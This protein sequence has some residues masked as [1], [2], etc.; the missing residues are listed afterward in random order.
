MDEVEDDLSG[1][2][3]ENLNSLSRSR[4]R[5]NNNCDEVKK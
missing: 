4:V 1:K 5:H 3:M 2:P